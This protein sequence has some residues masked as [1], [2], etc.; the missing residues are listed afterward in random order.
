VPTIPE[1]ALFLLRYSVLSVGIVGL[2]WGAFRFLG[3]RW[4]EQQF[5]R[6]MEAFKHARNRELEQLRG[7]VGALL[8]RTQKLHGKQFEVLPKAWVKLHDAFNA[9]EIAASPGWRTL[10][11]SMLGEVA[12]TELLKDA[13]FAEFQRQEVLS[14]Q[15]HQRQTKYD[16]LRRRY[17]I[18]GH[19]N[20]SV[21]AHKYIARNGIFIEPTLR[22]KMSELDDLIWK[23]ITEQEQEIS[24]PN[25]REGR[26]AASEKFLKEGPLLHQQVER[27]IQ[28]ILWD[29][30][31]LVEEIEAPK[32]R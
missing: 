25:P 29:R 21:S 8:D 4:I 22:A 12:L 20:T 17:E 16:G 28:G 24:F 1:I 14:L 5:A 3:R 26:Y 7:E 2:A 15:G 27:E 23:A 18:Q 19:R 10:D 32:P 6:Q 31:L 9:G 30:R 11:V 13:P